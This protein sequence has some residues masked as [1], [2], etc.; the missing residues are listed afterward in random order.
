MSAQINWVTQAESIAHHFGKGKEAAQGDGSWMTLCPEHGDSDKPNLHV[1]AADDKILLHCHVC[2]DGRKKEIVKH[3]ADHF[4]L[5]ATGSTKAVPVLGRKERG[6][7][8]NPVPSNGPSLPKDCYIDKAHGRRAPDLMWAY[9]DQN[10]QV[11]MFNAR[12]NLQADDGTITKTYRRLALY[13][14][15]AGPEVPTWSWFG[16]DDTLPLYGLEQLIG[17]WWLRPVMLVE[18]EKAADAARE[19]FKETI[20]LAFPGGANNY[21]RVNWE[22]LV[23]PKKLSQVVIWPDNDK[24]GKAMAEG[25]ASLSTFLLKYDIRTKVV[26]V[27][28]VP[29]LTN[30]WDLADPLPESWTTAHL[31]ELLEKAEYAEVADIAR[32]SRYCGTLA[33][34]SLTLEEFRKTSQLL[35]DTLALTPGSRCSFCPQ[36]GRI[37]KPADLTF[38]P[39]VQ[40][41]WVYLTRHKSF[42]NVRTQEELDSQGFNAKWADDP[43]YALTG[44]ASATNRLL[45]DPVT[46]KAYDYGYFPKGRAIVTDHNGQRRLN[47]WKGFA[48][49]PSTAAEPTPWLNLGTYL[50]TDEDMREHI[51]NWLAFTVQHPDKKINHGLLLVSNTQGVGK[52]TFVEPLRLIFGRGNAK[53]IGS[54]ALDSQFNEYLLQTKLLI[55]T[56][57]DTIGHRNSTYDYLKP[58]LAAPP[59]QL[60]INVKGLKQIEI[61]NLVQVI[62]FSNKMVPVAIEDN[63]RRLAIYD[64]QHSPDQRWTSAQ[65]TEY[66]QWMYNGGPAQV[67]GWLMKRDLSKFDHTAPAPNSEAKTIMAE[68]SQPRMAMLL[69]RIRDK[70]APFHSDL[71][72]CS[73]VT[74]ALYSRNNNIR[75]GEFERYMGKYNAGRI[76]VRIRLDD[77]SRNYLFACRHFSF[78]DKQSEDTLRRAYRGQWADMQ[79]LTNSAAPK[80]AVEAAAKMI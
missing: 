39:D 74:E 35:C 17:E 23:G 37:P 69:D 57:L 62:A 80:D 1:T 28:D 51:Y 5:S 76:T 48:L 77:G 67:M 26:P 59:T 22:P 64:I 16:P 27:F 55:I 53:D 6:R 13:C 30:K 52:D 33:E 12:F 50:I 11:M 40:L 72:L 68:G 29:Q 70:V 31:Y 46:S 43:S 65:F 79:P 38:I 36:Y 61:E 19:I 47:I 9:L 25:S 60:N 54:R 24:A 21:S 4:L 45:A 49:E 78:W 75:V 42:H 2:G 14:P 3:V 71:V 32:V 10:K 34:K 18:G 56:E 73:D 63:D 20:V 8:I 41:D 66:Y 44:P 7:W 58:L 15:L